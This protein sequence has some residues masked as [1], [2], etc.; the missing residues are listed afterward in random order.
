MGLIGGVSVGLGGWFA[1]KLLGFWGWWSLVLY[2]I[3]TPAVITL[4]MMLFCKFTATPK[5][6]PPT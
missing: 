4:A 5:E 6:T 3:I 1:I 2:L